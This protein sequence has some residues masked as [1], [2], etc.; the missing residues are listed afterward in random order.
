[1]ITVYLEIIVYHFIYNGASLIAQ[2]VN[3]PSTRE[4]ISYPLQHS[5]ASLVAAFIE[6]DLGLIPGLGRSLGERKG[7]PFQYS[8]LENSMEKSRG[9][10]VGHNWATFTFFSYIIFETH[11]GFLL[12]P[13]SCALSFCHN[14]YFYIFLNIIFINFILNNQLSFK[15]IGK[16]RKALFHYFNL[17]LFSFLLKNFF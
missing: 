7:Y 13:F 15:E 5:W 16:L 6:G 9:C 14:F 17:V 8:G 11:N 1:M 12:F 10:R 2:L 4:G 3:N